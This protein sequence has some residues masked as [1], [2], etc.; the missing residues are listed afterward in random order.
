MNNT[1]KAAAAQLLA[2]IIEPT[3]LEFRMKVSSKDPLY[4]NDI[5][6]ITL[7]DLLVHF[8]MCFP[9]PALEDLKKEVELLKSTVQDRE[10]NISFLSQKRTDLQETCDN[11]LIHI[12]ELQAQ[13]RKFEL[14]N[15]KL[16]RDLQ[17]S[18]SVATQFMEQSEN[19]QTKIN[20]MIIAFDQIKKENISVASQIIVDQAITNYGKK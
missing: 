10:T 5:Q 19:F 1:L 3:N 8:A 15:H 6:F 4:V 17:A 16:T 11:Q 2:T 13:A 9:Y 7:A 20:N 12:Q 18:E 14:K